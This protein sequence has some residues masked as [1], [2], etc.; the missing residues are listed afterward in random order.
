MIRESD[1]P[2]G[3]TRVILLLAVERRGLSLPLGVAA[4]ARSHEETEQT[5]RWQGHSGTIL[6]SRKEWC[7]RQHQELLFLH[8]PNLAPRADAPLPPPL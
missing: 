4:A 2:V 7:K 1:W 6:C 5:T 3:H 8:P